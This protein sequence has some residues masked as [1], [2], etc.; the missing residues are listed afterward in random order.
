[1][2]ASPLITANAGSTSPPNR[3]A[4]VA[5]KRGHAFVIQ[6]ARRDASAL[7]PRLELDGVMKSWAVTRGP[8]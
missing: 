4:K 7:R 1:M 5:G 3:K 8:V 2:L 6:K